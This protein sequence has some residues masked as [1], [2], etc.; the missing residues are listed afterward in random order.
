[1]AA[2]NKFSAVDVPKPGE[3]PSKEE[4]ENGLYRVQAVHVDGDVL[5]LGQAIQIAGDAARDIQVQKSGLVENQEVPMAY[6]RGIP[7]AP[8]CD[9]IIP[10]IS[11]AG[12][13]LRTL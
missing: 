3:G 8:A 10:A 12:P 5:I 9:S 6:L 7:A 4:R 2:N 13:S 11:D 1:M